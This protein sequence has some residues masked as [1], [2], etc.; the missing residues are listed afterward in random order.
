MTSRGSEGEHRRVIVRLVS[1]CEADNDIKRK[2]N[3]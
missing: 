2:V 3:R 1:S